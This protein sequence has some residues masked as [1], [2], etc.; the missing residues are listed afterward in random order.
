MCGR[1]FSFVG[2]DELVRRF[3]V[4]VPGNLQPRYNIAPTQPVWIVRKTER[5]AREVMP[6]RWGLVPGW[7]KEIGSAALINARAETVAE[8]PSFKGAYT[9]RRGIVPVSGWYEWRTEG[10]RK[11]PFAQHLPGYEMLG[12]ACIWEVWEGRGEGSWLE[13]CAI[14]TTDAYGPSA[15]VHHRMPVLVHPD[16]DQQWLF[17]KEGEP[18]SPQAISGDLLDKIMVR[19]ANADVNK[20]VIDGAYLLD[21]HA[22]PGGML[23]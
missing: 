19:E 17:G 5:G 16:N 3:G 18:P 4:T 10:K 9:Y 8:K 2:P 14:I 21:P 6:V 22:A 23:L 13:S 11:I 15:A 7:A 20:A 1:F 12:L